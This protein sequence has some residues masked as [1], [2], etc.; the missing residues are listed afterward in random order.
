AGA[1]GGEAEAGRRGDI[2]GSVG[3]ADQDRVGAFGGVE[4]RAPAGAAIGR[5]LDQRS[6]FRPADGQ[7]PVAGEEVG[8]VDTG[9]AGQGYAYGGGY[10]SIDLQRP[11]RV[12]H[13]AR[14]VRGVRRL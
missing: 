12:G 13:R 7:R 11:W 10:G 1:V 5:V 14:E 4:A 8:A 3:L 2:A 9:I 6:G